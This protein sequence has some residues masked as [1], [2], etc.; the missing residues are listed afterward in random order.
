MKECCFINIIL[1]ENILID[2]EVFIDLDYLKDK[3]INAIIHEI[4]QKAQ[5]KMKNDFEKKN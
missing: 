4:E 2:D 3:K 1:R 5:T